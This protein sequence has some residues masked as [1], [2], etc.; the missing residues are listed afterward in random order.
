M[1]RNWKSLGPLLPIAVA[2]LGIVALAFGGLPARQYGLKLRIPGTDAAPGG[3]TGGTNPVFAGKLIPGAGQPSELPGAWPQFRGPNRD[4]LAAGVAGLA[5]DWKATP[6]RELWGLD[7]GEGY[8]GVAVRSRPGLPPRLRPRRQAKRAAL[9]LAG[10]R[11]GA[12]ALHLSA[13]DQ[14]QPRHD[15]DGAGGD[16]E[17]RR[18]V[19]LE[20]QCALP[21]RRDRRTHAGA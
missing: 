5:R 16:G 14:A 21:R 6:P 20:V 18:R 7:V 12:L 8:A 1:K 10:G 17:I 19:R 11:E 9:P 4:G 3:E 13:H 15:A 2:L